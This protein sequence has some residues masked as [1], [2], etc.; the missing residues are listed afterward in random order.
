MFMHYLKVNRTVYGFRL[1]CKSACILDS[2]VS[3]L[4]ISTLGIVRHGFKKGAIYE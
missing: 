2:M 4:W 1:K 3:Y